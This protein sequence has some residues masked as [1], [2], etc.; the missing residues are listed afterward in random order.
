[1]QIF[2]FQ[3]MILVSLFIFR[4]MILAKTS[5]LSLFFVYFTVNLKRRIGRIPVYS[6]YLYKVLTLTRKVLG[7][8]GILDDA[9]VI[10]YVENI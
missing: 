1:M 5:S 8:L 6:K 2:V 9:A 7:L 10:T 3:K 4:K